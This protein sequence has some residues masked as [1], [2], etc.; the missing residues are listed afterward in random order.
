MRL[1]GQADLKINLACLAACKDTRDASKK[2]L[3]AKEGRREGRKARS[4]PRSYSSRH[5]DVC[6]VPFSRRARCWGATPAAGR[7]AALPPLDPWLMSL[8]RRRSAGR[9]RLVAS[10]PTFDPRPVSA[11]ARYLAAQLR[12]NASRAAAASST[13]SCGAG[14]STNAPRAGGGAR[15]QPKPTS[16][17]TRR[18][19]GGLRRH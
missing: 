3:R 11:Q 4:A 9:P 12:A 17:R 16:P 19:H 18:K 14:G 13:R 2:A 5:R 10:I 6:A 15:A 1:Q 7:S 8:S